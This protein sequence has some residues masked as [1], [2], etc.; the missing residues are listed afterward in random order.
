MTIKLPRTTIEEL[1]GLVDQLAKEDPQKR[2]KA[3]VRLTDYERTGK[4]PLEV[5]IDLSQNDHPS[6]SMYAISALGRN[7]QPE[8]VDHLIKLFV[9]HKR[10]H[11]LFL[12]TIID[13]LGETKSSK[14]SGPLLEIL[15]IKTGL[16]KR[17]LGRRSKKEDEE[18]SEASKAKEHFALPALRALEKI[19]DPK[20]SEKLGEFL[21]HPDYLVRCNTIQNIQNCRLTGFIEKLKEMS[22][23]DEH[24][25]VRESADIA[26]GYLQPLPP[27]LN[28]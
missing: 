9:K 24:E 22:K 25:L 14:A 19:Q 5:L 20:A 4:I 12:E 1:E 3:M 27:E 2:A 6:L 13:A 7:R 10:S 17:L 23:K 15:G 28:N 16:V 8:A 18:D 11:V 26:H 21:D